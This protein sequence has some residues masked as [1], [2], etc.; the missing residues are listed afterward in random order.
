MSALY[1]TNDH[2]ADFAVGSIPADYGYDDEGY[3]IKKTIL[4]NK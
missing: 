2:V 4:N 1:N 3:I